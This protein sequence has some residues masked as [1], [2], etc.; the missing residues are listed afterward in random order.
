MGNL[1]VHHKDFIK[2]VIIY[3]NVQDSKTSII[4]TLIYDTVIKEVDYMFLNR[5]SV[6]ALTT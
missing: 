2:V 3:Y 5:S 1:L 4:V 6:E